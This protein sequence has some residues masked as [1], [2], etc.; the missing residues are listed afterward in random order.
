MSIPGRVDFAYAF[1]TPHRLT[2]ARPD[3]GDKTLLDLQSGSLRMAWTYDSPARFPLGAFVTPV[4]GW[5]LRLTPLL[6]GQPFARSTWRRLEGHLPVLEN[7]Y[8]DARAYMRLEVAGAE[9]AA[10][11]RLWMDNPGDRPHRLGLRCERTGSFFG[12]NPAWV[13]PSAAS[14]VLLAGWGDRADRV[15]VLGLGGEQYAAP[16]ANTMLMEWELAPGEER[17]GWLVRPYRAYEADLGALRATPRPDRGWPREFEAA[18]EEW[19]QLLARACR[20]LIPDKGAEEAY[21]ACLGD[22]FIMRE[23]IAQ[24]YVAAS[25]GTEVYRAPNS[26]EAAI[27]AVALDQAGFHQEAESGYQM[28]LDQQEPDGNWSEPKGWGHL[29]WGGAG[30]KAWAIRE[31][32]LTTHDRGY[33]ERVYPCLLANSRWQERQRQRSRVLVN[34][35]KPLTYGLMP[36][37]MGDGG[38]KDGDDL[39][40][41]FLPHNIWAVFADRVALEAAEVL[42]KREDLDELHAI[43]RRSLADL[44]EALERGAIREEGYRWIPG[45]PGKTTGSRWAVLNALFPCGLLPPDHEL[46][47]GTIRK[48]ESRLSP[49]GQPLNTGWMPEGSWVAITLDNL[50]EAHLARGEGD[51]AVEYLYSSLNHGTPLYTWCEERGKEPGSAETSGDRQHLFTPVAVARAIRDLLVMEQGEGLHLALGASRG[52]LVAGDTLSVE[53]A[54]THFGVVSFEMR[55]DPEAKRLKAKAVFPQESSLAWAILHVRLLKGLRVRSLE[56]GAGASIVLGG[57]GIEWSAPRGE[58]AVEAVIG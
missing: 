34:D 43:Y 3:S 23:P 6:D 35:E 29:M 52:W 17:S 8:L 14:D 30:F 12:Y 55:Y 53:R 2:V 4:T 16:T 5:E 41:V 46:I 40:G 28:P 1:A 32:Y 20:L 10:L 45:V 15:L 11:V 57:K 51:A 47:T 50:A 22:L 33:L 44:L 13:D 9:T 21:Y 56:G 27:V 58:V 26:F 38:L 49:G 42:R 18:L 37:G 25:P 7:E 36:R 39:Y 19:R 24:G 54:P 48:I 31:H